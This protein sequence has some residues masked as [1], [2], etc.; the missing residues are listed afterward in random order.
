VVDEVSPFLY[1][2]GYGET[3][4]IFFF[5]SDYISFEL[6]KFMLEVVLK[7]FLWEEIVGTGGFLAP[8]NTGLKVFSVVTDI[9]LL[10]R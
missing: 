6:L 7:G 10:V 8:D 5:D 4:E 9:E 1:F 2:L 3:I